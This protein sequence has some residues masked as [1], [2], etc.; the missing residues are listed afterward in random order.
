MTASRAGEATIDLR[1]TKHLH[2]LGLALSDP[3]LLRD[4]CLIGG[5]WTGAPQL[6]V[7]DPASG[8]T[9]G[10]VPDLG[11]PGATAAVAAASTAFPA[12][13]ALTAEARAAFL[14]RWRDAIVAH[15]DDLAQI[16][17]REQGK[18]LAEAL[19][20]ID[21]AAS[22]V[23]FYAE[24]GR[25]LY[26]E[27]I[28][29]PRADTRIVVLRQP[30]GVVATITPWN[31]PAAMV[32]R[33]VAPA[34]AVGCTTVL[35]PAPETPLTALALAALAERAGLPAGVFNVVTGDAAAIGRILTEH[36]AVRAVSFTGSTEVGKLLMRQAASSVKKLALELGGNA[37]FIVFEDADLDAAADGCMESK[38]RN[39]GQTCVCA[40]RIYVQDDVY[41]PFLARLIARATALKVGSGLEPGVQ[42]G[43]LI[44]EAAVSKVERHIADAVAK[45]A[46]VRL[47]GARRPGGRFF[48]PTVLSEMGAEMAISSEETFGPV[49]AVYRFRDEADALE[50]A[51][52]TS[53]GLAAYVYARDLGRVIRMAEG[54]QVGMVGVNAA[55][56]G[57]DVVPFGGVKESGLGREGSRHGLE[58]FTDLKYV[59]LGGVS[60]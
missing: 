50:Q 11:A 18:P 29:S 52:A 35:K 9:L 60:R 49:A 58:E 13:S 33:K 27:T 59:L 31:F 17:T 15:R 7:R 28:P 19:G 39:T 10:A 53:F 41:E 6:A 16:L 20:E 36:P 25:R 47:G 26:G 14:R 21:Y 34:L 43:P 56:L 48:S 23:A 55:K 45:G 8:A 38:F 40:N 57:A 3:A 51:N 46:R 30:V 4:R 44:S 37:P 54:L 42:I 5:A 12:W 32:T 1:A 24:E 2:S 22:F